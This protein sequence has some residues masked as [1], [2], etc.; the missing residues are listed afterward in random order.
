M[1]QTNVT[2]A[3][4]SMIILN[5]LS[6]Q[7]ASSFGT[8][9]PGLVNLKG[10][11]YALDEN[12][13]KMPGD[14]D[15]RKAEGVIYTKSLDIP[16]RD[17]TEGFPGVTNRYEWFG[18]IYTGT[19]EIPKAGV[20][21]W[22][23]TSDDG[24]I[25]WIDDKLVIDN[26]G[27]HGFNSVDGDVELTAGMHRLKLW[28]FQ[29]PATE[30][31]LQL[32]IKPPAEDQKIFNLDDYSSGLS[33]A[34]KKVNATTTKEG[35]KIEL[36]NNILFDVNKFDLKPSAEETIAVVAEIIK[37]YPGST[38]KIQ[39][40]TDATGN[41]DANQQLSENRAKSVMSALTK[42]GIP[43]DIKLQPE[44]FG[45]SKPVASNDTE[46]GRAKNRRVEIM[47]KM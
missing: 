20:Y 43:P 44:G 10:T 2:A 1:K 35:I 41:A 9:D 15:K 30:I 32:F 18:I 17:F 42:K 6:A 29:G 26:D 39:G 37:S 45:A 25:L 36:P 28:Y 46:E 11:I 34:A 23:T 16:V 24:S 13:D 31:G 21:T 3:I 12:T 4:V 5:S 8:K 19:F 22:T 33:D 14:L 38:V 27:V 47:I 7:N 40:H